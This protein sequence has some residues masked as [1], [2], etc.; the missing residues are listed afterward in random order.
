MMIM[1]ALGNTKLIGGNENDNWFF[2]HDHFLRANVFGL[3]NVHLGIQQSI[4]QLS[5]EAVD[6]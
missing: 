5:L 2:N 1:Q 4:K 3:K 6:C